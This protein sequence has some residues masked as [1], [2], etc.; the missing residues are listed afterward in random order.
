MEKDVSLQFQAPPVP[1]VRR[2]Q[3][4]CCILHMGANPLSLSKVTKG[5]LALM[6][7]QGALPQGGCGGYK[8]THLS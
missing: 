6:K 7:C 8:P 1:C 3:G 5:E 2:Q 4:P